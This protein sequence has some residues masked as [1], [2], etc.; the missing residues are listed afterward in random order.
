MQSQFK[1]IPIVFCLMLLSC[2]NNSNRTPPQNSPVEVL[3]TVY[4]EGVDDDLLTAGLGLVG[5]RSTAPALPEL[6]SAAELRQASYYHQFKAL[7]DLS[8]DGGFGTFYGFN[9][10]QEPIAG[11]EYWSQRSVAVDVFHTVVLQLP[12]NF[13]AAKACLVVAPSSGSRNVLGAVGT[14]GSWALIHGCAVVYT[15]KGTGTQVASED[16]FEYQIDGMIDTG[17]DPSKDHLH[18]ATKLISASAKHVVQ[19]HP[20]SQVNPEQY[21]GEFVI[22]AA[23]YGLALLRQEKGLTRDNIKVIAASVSNGGGA[24]LRAAEINHNGLIDAVVAAEPQINLNHQYKVKN[25]NGVQTISVKTLIELSMN[26]SLYEPCAALHESLNDAPFKMNTVMI[27]G[28]QQSRCAAL[29]Q[30]GYI[31]A[32]DL[33][34][35]ISESLNKIKQLK[36]EPS[37]LQLAPLNTLANMWGAINHTYSNSYL[38]KSARDNLCQSAMSAFTPQGLPRALSAVEKSSMFAISNGIAPS[39]GVE[40]AYTN[41]NNE[42]QSRMVLAADFGLESQS[43]FYQLLSD[44]KMQS[45][46]DMIKAQTEDNQV[47][48]I[49]LHGQADGTVAI[50]H[51]SR[52]YFHRNQSSETVNQSMRY[53]EI[54][55]TQHF[56]AFLAY[57]GFNQQFVPMH[58]YFEQA[59]ELM[60]D[61]LFSAQA[62]PLSQ[63]IKTQPRGLQSGT[64]PALN[65]L[66]IP[67]INQQVMHQ[68]TVN[69]QQL[70]VE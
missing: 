33:T 46:L 59:L 65:Q 3:K 45:A 63:L 11:Y 30:S 32:T 5:L 60:Y 52:A 66:H 34:G 55:N 69:Q 6:A 8:T 50:N 49:I 61:H 42:V 18:E 67:R 37:A 56:D 58:P 19:K 22:D 62:L 40:L 39:N 23:Q 1:Y 28:L 4:Y 70:E 48:T 35:Q 29:H 13:K 16:K 41:N 21:W 20:Y 64:V 15:D 51:A 14:S 57:P 9:A 68:I 17:K 47:P 26:M 24:V 27:Q 43:C 7:N 44:S 2:S 31:Q 36:I 53:Y 54:E 12:D 10:S 38:K 25:A